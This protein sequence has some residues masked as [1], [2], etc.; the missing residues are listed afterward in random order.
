VWRLSFPQIDF[1]A[2]SAGAQ[3]FIARRHGQC[4][5]QGMV[6]Q[7]RNLT[8]WNKPRKNVGILCEEA[9]LCYEK[10]MLLLSRYLLGEL[11]KIGRVMEYTYP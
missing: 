6:T 7:A 9:L 8:N 3:Q 1:Y 10:I 4:Y 11:V 2:I 5:S